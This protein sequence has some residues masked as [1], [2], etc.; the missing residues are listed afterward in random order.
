MEDALFEAGCDDAILSFRNGIAYLDFDREAENLEKG[1]I[2]AIHQVEQTGMPL[3]VKRVE[4]SDFV[5]SAEIARRLH[6]SKQSVQQ[7][8]SGGRGDGDFPLPI[9]G[10]TAKTM[11]WSWQEVV[12]WFLEKKKL[13]EKSIYENAT[14]LKQLNESLDARHDEAQFKNIRRITKLIKKGRSEFV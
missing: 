12:G 1:V 7:L 5:T 10:V 3:S 2:S 4:P 9:A 8:I 14:T 6:R 11:L 13:D